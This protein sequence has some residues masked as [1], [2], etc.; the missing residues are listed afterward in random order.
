MTN[1]TLSTITL[2]AIQAL[3]STNEALKEASTARK[4]KREELVTA[5]IEEA[6]ALYIENKTSFDTYNDFIEAYEAEFL[7]EISEEEVSLMTV[8]ELVIFSLK[9]GL[10]K[11]VNYSQLTK[12]HKY[13]LFVNFSALNEA[14]KI[15]EEIKKAQDAYEIALLESMTNFTK[16]MSSKSSADLSVYKEVLAIITKQVK[17]EEKALEKDV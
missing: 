9:K 4:T 6:L 11:K 17:K 16:T 15:N 13:V 8:L 12:I 7:M 14:E 2:K 1:L 3:R 10:V 5:I